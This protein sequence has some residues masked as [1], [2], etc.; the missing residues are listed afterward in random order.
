MMRGQN[1]T[2]GFLKCRI[3]GHNHDSNNIGVFFGCTEDVCNLFQS[4]RMFYQAKY[5]KMYEE[6][7]FE[8]IISF[9]REILDD[10]V[11]DY[12]SRTPLYLFIMIQLFNTNHGRTLLALNNNFL[13][14]VRKKIDELSEIKES[15]PYYIIKQ[16]TNTELEVDIYHAR[17]L[18][19]FLNCKG[20]NSFFSEFDDSV[21][22]ADNLFFEV[23]NFL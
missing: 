10:C 13:L 17:L 15:H 22:D 23:I 4:I 12:S 11:N 21:V 14:Q 7:T 20:G 3:R 19:F 16:A 6:L 2:R 8:N 9:L 1:C 18:H 5:I